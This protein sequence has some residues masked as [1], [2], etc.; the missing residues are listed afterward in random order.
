MSKRIRIISVG[1]VVV[2]A[3]AGFWFSSQR[4]KV[5]AGEYRF[6][7]VERGDLEQVVSATGKLNATKTVQVGTQVSGQV[8]AIYADFNQ[9]VKKGQLIARIDP[10]LLE[11]AVR[12]ASADVERAQADYDQAKRDYDRNKGLYDRNVIAASEFDTVKHAFD[13]ADASL[14]ASQVSLER[15]RQNLAYSEIRTPID[16]VV[17]ERDVDVGQTVAA[18]LSAPQLFLIAEDLTR[19][20][21]LVSVDESDIGMIHEGQTVRFTVQA[22]PSRTFEGTVKQVRLQST[23]QENVVNYTVVVGVENT[24][25][26]LLPGMTATV[27]FLVADAHGVLKVSNTAIRFRATPEMLAAVRKGGAGDSAWARR[28]EALPSGTPTD[29]STRGGRR[30]NGGAGAANGAATGGGA[31]VRGGAGNGPSNRARLWYLDKSG[32]LAVLRVRTGVTDGTF[33][34]VEADSL[35]EGMQVIAGIATGSAPATTGSTNPFQSQ[36][37]RNTGFRGPPGM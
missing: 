35:R 11:Q 10:T 33:T 8:A 19:M 32:H 24:T 30:G 23:E 7:A 22:Y 20:E 9:H 36:N 21:I 26:L 34:E 15:A 17:V 6:V 1:A 4:G 5:A 29:A 18:S 13:V 31:A 12:S 14:K 37:R 25:G 2:L 3:A 28:A 27:D 16:G